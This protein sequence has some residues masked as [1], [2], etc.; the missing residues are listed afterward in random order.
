MPLRG[1]ELCHPLGGSQHME[2]LSA[3]C[4]QDE[5]W[6]K[7]CPGV[8]ALGSQHC[9]VQDSWAGAAGNPCTALASPRGISQLLSPP[10]MIAAS[11]CK[12]L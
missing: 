5:A 4:V 11:Q 2:F 3:G 1:R 7:P 10:D 8:K 12:Q 6:L 9:C